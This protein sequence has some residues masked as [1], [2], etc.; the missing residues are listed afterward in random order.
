MIKKRVIVL[1]RAYKN[2]Y[3]YYFLPFFGAGG[4][5]ITQRNPI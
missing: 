4:K 3:I 5:S 1:L 2:I